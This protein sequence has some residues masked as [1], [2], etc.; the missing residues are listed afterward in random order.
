[1]CTGAS[2]IIVNGK[3]TV[4]GLRRGLG[5]AMKDMSGILDE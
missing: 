4:N 1:M 2:P 5:R 3:T